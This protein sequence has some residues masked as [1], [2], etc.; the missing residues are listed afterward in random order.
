MSE[1]AENLTRII[2]AAA[3]GDE[4]ASSQLL[5]LVYDELRKL[6]RARM[7][8]I[9]PG[10][11]LQATALVHEAYLRITRDD[12][13]EWDGRA[14]FF[15][16]AARAMRDILVEDARRKASLKRG[17][18]RKRVELSDSGIVIDPP[19]E[20][21]LAVDEAVK[22]LEA[23]DPEKAR[24]VMLR[25]FTGLTTEETAQVLG[26]SVA[27]VERKW[28]FIRAWLHRELGESAPS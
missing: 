18:N 17:G 25:Y 22:K 4:Q 19:S 7:A 20:D 2:E 24:I 28:R 23:E 8:K 14:H 16:A 10:Q 1:S 3:Q 13:A 11:T 27:T 6:A 21:L 26:V 9:P 15:F 12:E 5:P